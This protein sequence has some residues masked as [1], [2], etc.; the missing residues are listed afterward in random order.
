MNLEQILDRFKSDPSIAGNIVRWTTFEPQ[1]GRYADFPAA[2]APRLVDALTAR[3]IDKL[4]VHQR[5]AFDSI[6]G[7]ADSVI[8]TPTASGKTLCYNLPVLNAMLTDPDSRALYLFPTK[9]LGQDQTV[10]LNALIDELGADIKTYTFDGDTPG[11]VR[12]AIRNAGHIVVT[13]P[14]MLHS[15]ILPHHTR[16]I[17]LFENLKYVVIDEMHHYRGVFGSHL[18]NVIR[19][20]QR[21]C[22]FYGSDPL[23]VLCSATIAN[24]DELAERMIGRPVRVIDDNG[25]PS[26][27]KHVIV[28]NPPVIDERLGVR[29]SA[30]NESRRLAE[31]FLREKIQTIVFAQYRT[32]VETLLLYLKESVGKAFD[33]GVK[34]AGYRGGYLPNE[35]RAIEQGLRSGEITGVVSTNALELGVDIGSLDVSIIL[36]FPGSISSFWQQAGR[37]GRRQGASVT[38]FVANSA[39]INQFLCTQS[40]YLFNRS[41]ESGVVDP[42][43]LI[44]RSSHLK[45]ASFELPLYANEDFGADG[46]LEMLEYLEDQKVLRRSGDKFHWSSEIYPAENVSLRSAAPENFVIMNETDNDRAIGEVDY[47][48][49]P[50]FIHPEAIY[51]HNGAKYQVTQLDWEGRKCYV[52]EVDIDYYTDAETKTDLTVLTVNDQKSRAGGE[53]S[54]GEVTIR[55]VTTLYKKIKFHTHENVGFGQ[56]SMPEMEMTTE[57]FWFTF[58][59]NLKETLGFTGEQTGA[60]LHG[61][62]AALGK[63]APLWVMCDPRDLRY[64]AQ[65]RA[66]FTDRPTI[67][68]YENIPGGVGL[69]QKLFTISDDLFEACIAHIMGCGCTI[70][71]PSCVGPPLLVGQAG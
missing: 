26:A 53:M 22:R 13:N 5:L 58:P 42:D 29:K 34:I 33:R 20:L 7:G 71:C 57:A 27:T 40:D 37:A 66:P 44:I 15:G 14:D 56:L 21:I 36:G 43:N 49:A 61:A 10:N 6:A 48:S 45:C 25:A 50:F 9:A 12:R 60:A 67:F 3:G 52:K 23:F 11:N 24:P 38:I 32:Q 69:S 62:A 18:S 28:Y 31:W 1:P 39:A 47:F 64:L 54:H 41:A 19:R 59:E 63:I 70:G 30:I 35:R 17:K 2:L 16:W 68:L 65:V 55:S 46:T 8:V 51:L 4:Y